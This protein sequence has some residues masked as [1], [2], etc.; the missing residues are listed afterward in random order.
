MN[1]AEARFALARVRWDSRADRGR[2][3]ALAG[4]AR[5]GYTAMGEGFAEQR[6]EVDAWLARRR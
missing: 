5:D 1:L 6:A 2:A 3:R 4:Q